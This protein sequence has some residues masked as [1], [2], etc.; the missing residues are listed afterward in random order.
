MVYLDRI[1]GKVQFNTH[2]GPPRYLSDNEENELAQFLQSC[3]SIG[4][5]RTKKDVLAIVQ[6]VVE[7]KGL[8][9]QVSTGW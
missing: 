6:S 2:S 9:V 5:G 7:S 8:K 4:Y 3:A 1:T